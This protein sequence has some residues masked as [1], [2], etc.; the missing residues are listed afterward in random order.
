MNVELLLVVGRDGGAESPEGG[1]EEEHL[2]GCGL[3][4][5]ATPLPREYT[6]LSLLPHNHTT[7]FKINAEEVRFKKKRFRYCI[8][9]KFD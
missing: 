8:N 9:M 4:L 7:W 5:S 2:Q 6:T 1:E 3:H